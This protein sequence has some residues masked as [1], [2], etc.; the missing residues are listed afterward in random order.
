MIALEQLMTWKFG[1]YKISTCKAR[2][3]LD[4]ICE[5][6]SQTYWA[7]QRPRSVIKKTI[8]NSLCYGVYHKKEQV[9]FARVVTDFATIYWVCDV[10]IDKNFRGKGLGKKLMRCIVNTKG[11]RN[12]GGILATR[13][14]HGL[15]KQSGFT[16]VDGRF[17]RRRPK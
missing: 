10:F 15:Y 13:D 6:M 8:K 9:G 14:A 1:N 17:M 7:A 3:S 5:F 2:L 16:T 11:L 4:R 12:L